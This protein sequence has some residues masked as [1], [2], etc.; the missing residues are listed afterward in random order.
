[1]ERSDDAE[2]VGT[3]S[4]LL[5][6]FP[7]LAGV[8]RAADLGAGSGVLALILAARSQ[9]VHVDLVELD[10]T[11]AALAQRNA[12]LNGLDGRLTVL[13]RDLRSL[14]E[15]EVGRYGLIVSNPPYRAIGSGSRPSERRM[16]ARQEGTCTLSELV[17]S[18][19]RLLGDGGR[20]ALV[21]PCQRLAEAFCALSSARL[22][23][24]R[25]R[26]VQARAGKAPS[27]ALIECRKGGRPGLRVEPV[28]MLQN[29][30][31]TVPS[32]VHKIYH[33]DKEGL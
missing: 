5:G 1:M 29:P 30:D 23:P 31:G 13:H 22:E 24:K 15:S 18:A 9:A 11:A 27:V 17:S 6:S 19:A 8:S 3:D 28:L 10:A 26:L 20:F 2:P 12:D 14:R 4:M 33:P 7:S 32:E 16:G 21:Y 25:L